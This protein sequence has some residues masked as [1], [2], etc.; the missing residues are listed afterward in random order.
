MSI[1]ATSQNSCAGENS[2]PASDGIGMPTTPAKECV[3][4]PHSTRRPPTTSA[5]ARV[6]RAKYQAET[7]KA[8]KAIRAPA[9]AVMTML[10]RAEGQKLQSW[11]VIASAVT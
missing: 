5:K 2:C 9:P 3:R 10:M 7:R 1:A 8:G 6:I 4:P 11:S